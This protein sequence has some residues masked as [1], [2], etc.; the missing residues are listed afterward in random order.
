VDAYNHERYIEQ[1]L[2]S[3]LEQGLS[4]AELEIVVV[5]DGSTD[6]TPSIIQKFAP[7][8]KHLRKK[9]GGQASAFNAGFA[10]TRGEIVAFLDGDDWWAKEKLLTVADA[11]ERHPAVAAVGHGHYEFHES[12]NETCLRVPQRPTLINMADREATR[13]AS[14]ERRFLLPSAL[15]V[16]RKVLEWIMPI[17]EEMVFIA[18]VPL[19]AA[20]LVMGTLILDQPLFYYRYH[21]QNLYSIDPHDD[22]KVCRKYQM[23]ELVCE[24]LYRRLVELGVPEES[25][26]EFLGGVWVEA[27]RF[28]LARFGGS[29]LE[30]FR[31]EM[32]AFRASVPNP[33][34]SYR[35]F[36]YLT[37]GTALLLPAQSF[38]KVRNWY[39]EKNLGRYRDRLFKANVAR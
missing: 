19:Q 22:A 37:L 12:T 4:P 29:R 8:V 33:S 20:A 39:A 15:T 9:N 27:K 38:Y 13:L 30:A 24:R 3:V 35:L 14:L 25:V 34:V 28:R 7:R 32:Q 36:R 18:D 2:V 26:S 31:T 11:L 17:P 10:E 16:R 21:A 1:A 23:T 6:Q 5:D